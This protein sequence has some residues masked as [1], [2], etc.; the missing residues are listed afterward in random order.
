MCCPG[1]RCFSTLRAAVSRPRQDGQREEDT[2]GAGKVNARARMPVLRCGAKGGVSSGPI[3][4]VWRSP[5]RF[6]RANLNAG[7]AVS[8][9]GGAQ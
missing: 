6:A 4:I 2:R 7:A 3:L 9:F 1:R 8:R 5:R